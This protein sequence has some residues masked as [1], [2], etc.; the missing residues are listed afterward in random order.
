[1]PCAANGDAKNFRFGYLADELRECGYCFG[2]PVD[3][4]KPGPS[5][6][7]QS[8]Q[9]VSPCALDL[10]LECRLRSRRCKVQGLLNGRAIRLCLFELIAK[11]CGMLEG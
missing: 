7:G 5:I 11:Y 10:D 3:V 4:S 6:A 9:L 8:L 2:G 1:M